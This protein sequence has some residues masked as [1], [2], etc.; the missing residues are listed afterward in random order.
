[1][2]I[3]A[4]WSGERMK[5]IEVEI[6]N[7]RGNKFSAIKDNDGTFIFLIERD[8]HEGLMI[9][10]IKIEQVQ[11]LAEALLSSI[12]ETAANGRQ[13]SCKQGDVN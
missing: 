1:M 8:D 12:A 2:G 9:A 4:K 13:Q 6:R 11:Y 3:I 7:E 5:G 10:D